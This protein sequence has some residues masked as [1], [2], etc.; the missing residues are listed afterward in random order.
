MNILLTG[1]CGY[2]G[3]H[4]A[5]E[6]TMAGH[7]V[8]LLDNFSNSKESIIPLIEKIINKKINY[9]NCDVL[10]DRCVKKILV[11]H[12][13]DAV[14]HFAG[15]KAVN[16]SLEI[17]I[18]YYKSNVQGTI[19]LIRAMNECGIYQIIFSSSAA[20]YGNPEYLPINELHPLNPVN[21]YGKTKLVVEDMLKYLA[22]SDPRWKV[23][24]LRYFNPVG[25][26]DSGLLGANPNGPQSSLMSSISMVA[27]GE[28][29][30]LQVHGFDYGTLDGSGVRD[31][32]HVQDLAT[33]H[34]SAMDSIHNL[35]GWNAFNLGTGEGHSVLEVLKIYEGVCHVSIPRKNC[36]RRVGDVD[37]SYADVS[38]ARSILNWRAKKNLTQMCQSQHN[39]QM[40]MR[41]FQ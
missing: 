5:I 17:P 12:E 28:Q 11:D 18:E 2:I 33:G 19:S 35:Q 27:S 6:L 16:E 37:I 8:V 1:G 38:K 24:C 4:T 26:H 32:I 22:A 13:I 25:G 30:L 14:I 41:N 29:E 3:S 36:A 34:L 31:F 21:P 9:I 23:I 39:W 15:K 10:D 20:V 40:R 7:E